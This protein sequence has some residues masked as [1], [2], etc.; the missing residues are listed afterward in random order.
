MLH[1]A[2]S[3]RASRLVSEERP[4]W[5]YGRGCK[6]AGYYVKLI[7]LSLPS[8]DVA[9][10]RVAARVAQGG[11]SVSEEVV[12]RRFDAGLWNFEHLY[13][14]LVDMWALYDNSESTPRLSV[15]K[16]NA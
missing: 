14:E 1:T 6:A 5:R 7:F 2:W 10:A 15:S 16:D 12:R 8:A 13:R 9:V 4:G 3:F 11:H